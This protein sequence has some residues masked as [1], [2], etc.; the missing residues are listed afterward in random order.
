LQLFRNASFSLCCLFETSDD[1]NAVDTFANEQQRTFFAV[2]INDGQDSEFCA[3]KELIGSNTPC[4]IPD[5]LGLLP[6]VQ[7]DEQPYGSGGVAWCVSLIL[8]R[9]TPD[10][11]S[12]GCP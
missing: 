11:S 5:A 10:A 9:D 3:I 12:C 4:S 1:I 2:I 7:G 6:D 8:V